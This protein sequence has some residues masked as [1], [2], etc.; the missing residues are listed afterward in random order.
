MLA[1]ILLLLPVVASAGLA[2]AGTLF[3]IRQRRRSAEKTGRKHPLKDRKLLR[4]PGHSS[5]EKAVL[6]LDE[7]ASLYLMMIMSPL[8]FGYF[9][10]GLNAVG[11][12]KSSPF[13]IAA[14]II[15]PLISV[16]VSL[17]KARRVLQQR[18]AYQLGWEGEVATA[19]GLS[20][21]LVQGY[22][23]FHD[24]PFD[25]FNIDHVAIGPNGIF[26]I[27]TKTRVKHG[28][29]AYQVNYNGNTLEF[30][31][32]STDK[33]LKQALDQARQLEAWLSKGSDISIRPRAV[34]I[35]P[36]W[37]V[38][39]PN[40]NDFAVA[41]WP[42][43]GCGEFL[44]RLPRRATLTSEQVQRIAYQLETRCRDVGLSNALI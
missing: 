31:H 15:A 36:G 9:Y 32:F 18:R 20:S 4:L 8:A 30:P 33:P 7:I 14:F 6:A 11:L 2:V 25:G 28:A 34:V 35:L 12:I 19:E 13:T 17:Q 24:V 38:K 21:L 41:V 27:E 10:F 44:H 3:F 40:N 23:I 16:A 26:S 39:Q 42:A 43:K 1:V 37:F 5:R 29:A 22:Q